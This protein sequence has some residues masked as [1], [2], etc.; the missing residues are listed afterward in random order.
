[1]IYLNDHFSILIIYLF[2]YLFIY[3]LDFSCVRV[4]FSDVKTSCPNQGDLQRFLSKLSQVTFAIKKY[5]RRHQQKYTK[6]S[7]Y[8]DICVPFSLSGLRKGYKNHHFSLEQKGKPRQST[9]ILKPSRIIDQRYL[10]PCSCY[11]CAGS[12]DHAISFKDVTLQLQSRASPTFN[13]SF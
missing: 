8:K 12:R 13:T 9:S 7:Q 6:K 11:Y 2:I 4:F 5:L 3:S 1:M 10:A